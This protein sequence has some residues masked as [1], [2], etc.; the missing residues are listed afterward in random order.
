MPRSAVALLVACG[1]FFARASAQLDDPSS[2]TA[3][4]ASVLN[5]EG[6]SSGPR[7][8]WGG[9]PPETIQLDRE[10]VHSGKAAGRIARVA[11]SPQ[12]FSSLTRNVRLEITGQRIELRGWLKTDTVTGRSELWLRQDGSD[13]Q[14]AFKNMQQQALSGTTDWK[15]YS[16]FL[17]LN[18][19]A[20]VLSFGV[21]QTGS[22]TTWADDLQLLVDGKPIWEAPKAPPQTR[23]VLDRDTEF[24]GGSN[25]KTA[26]L[27]PDQSRRLATLGRV[28]GFLKYHH[29]AVTAGNFH[30]DFEL[31]RIMPAVLAAATDAE[32]ENVLVAWIARLGPLGPAAAGEP[33][34]GDRYLTPDLRWLGA[35]SDSLRTELQAVHNARSQT[36]TQFYLTLGAHV[37]NPSFENE[38]AYPKLAFPDPGYQLLALFRYWNIIHYWFPYRDLIDGDWDRTLEEF[39]PRFAA[40]PDADDYRRQLLALIARVSDT[41]SNLWSGLY[42]RPPVGDGQLTVRV[43]FVR[44][45]PVITASLLA[46]EPEGL[47]IGDV[48][49]ALDGRPVV[50]LIR[51]WSPYYAASN[52]PTRLRDIAAALGR[53][54][55][56][57]V[58]VEIERGGVHQTITTERVAI[59][60][61]PAP[62]WHTDRPG[63]V[64]QQLG[65]D[66]AYLK[67]SAVKMDEARS[68]A[69][70]ALESKGWIIDARN[71]P[72]DFLVF[73]L[74]GYLMND[75]TDFVQFT[76]GNP[77][78]PGEFV[79]HRGDAI[80]PLQPHYPGRV[81][82]LVNETTQSA[83]E[84]HAM[85]FRASPGAIVVGSTTAGAD[86]DASTIPLP[87]G[88]R[89]MIS[90]IGVFYADRRPTQRI[91]IVPDIVCEPTLAG[92]REGRDEVLEEALRQI[93]GPETPADTIRRLAGPSD[94]R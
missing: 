3:E 20:H 80:R 8:G 17:P 26:A 35:L 93:L 14:I 12:A 2:P 86:G 56:G 9:G 67:L 62:E 53:G 68:Y 43:R 69:R 92:I 24:A 82:I 50:D 22:G 28:W 38:P 18:P 66:V 91:G 77:A 30:W 61:L 45:L 37:R 79:F 74:G 33:L 87:G 52:E 49:L 57:P 71:Y 40:A 64:F 36:A 94:N 34:Q 72:S 23:T 16:I 21:V 59:N 88:Q 7:A 54:P 47:H 46:E 63:P 76:S 84:Y 60:K 58:Q 65:P 55:V 73:A 44:Q 27:T 29:P 10:V 70:H 41:H 75:P 83:A 4:L 89:S 32:A 15:E 19:K 25:I 48:I 85:A 78:N 39:V 13:G 11:D 31:F 6:E 42:S 81:V 51:E 90:G 1:L 5:F